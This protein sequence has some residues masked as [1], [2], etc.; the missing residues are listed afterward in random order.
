MKNL[1]RFFVS[2]LVLSFVV[3]GHAYAY[4]IEVGD[5]VKFQNGTYGTTAGGEF[6][7]IDAANGD[8]LFKTFCLEYSEHLNY[9]ST[10][11][12]DSISDTAYGGGYEDGVPA[13]DG[14][15]ISD[16]TKWLYWNFVTGGLEIATDY[17]YSDSG[18]NA[19]QRAIWYLEGEIA[20]LTDSLAEALIDAAGVAIAAGDSLGNVKVMNVSFENGGLAQSQLVADVAPV[21]EP[22]TLLLMSAGGGLL[23]LVRRRKANK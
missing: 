5:S 13:V 15:P 22:S 21:P 17:T 10:F 12:V 11:I 6:N 8:F 18:I 1:I 14:D 19:L 4:P 3:A 2:L 7:I 9:S 16:E 20:S 23:W